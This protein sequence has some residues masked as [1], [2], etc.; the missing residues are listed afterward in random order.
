MQLIRVTGDQEVPTN[1]INTGKLTVFLSS[2]V[3]QAEVVFIVTPFFRM[4]EF[5]FRCC[6]S[7]KLLVE[8]KSKSLCRPK[9]CDIRGRNKTRPEKKRFLQVNMSQNCNPNLGT[10]NQLR[11]EKKKRSKTDVKCKCYDLE[12]YSTFRVEAVP[13]KLNLH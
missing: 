9:S 11:K 1:W 10:L 6:E 2:I 13:R 8:I 7:Y 12:L 4:V 3:R 5:V